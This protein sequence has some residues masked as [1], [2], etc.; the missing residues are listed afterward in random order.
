MGHY[1]ESD[2]IRK[3]WDDRY[4]E[5]DKNPAIH[6]IQGKY[7]WFDARFDHILK[8]VIQGERVLEFGCG[9]AMY[10]VPMLRRYSLYYGVDVSPKA[11]EIAHRYHDNPRTNIQLIE[12][13]QVLPFPA[14]FFDCVF[15]ITVLQHQPISFRLAMIE[16]LKRVLRPNGVYIGL[17]WA[18]RHSA[19][20]DMPPIE[21]DDWCK[22]WR[23]FVIE[24]DIPPEHPDWRSDNVWVARQPR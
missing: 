16:E 1:T 22:A 17:E 13:N 2:N 14:Q 21:E 3:Y 8:P 23:P 15:T 6:V 9:N 20:W 11:I 5:W 24:R 7:A 10:S 19:S 12:P 18:D 4:I